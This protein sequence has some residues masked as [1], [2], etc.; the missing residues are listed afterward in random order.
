MAV[1]R[2]AAA[3]AALLAVLLVAAAP[4]SHAQAGAPSAFLGQLGGV[5]ASSPVSICFLASATEFSSSPIDPAASQ[6]METCL[7]AACHV[8]VLLLPLPMLGP[9][10]WN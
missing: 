3:S 9:A 4:T 7:A 8:V 1:S 5:N 2:L 10:F 6:C